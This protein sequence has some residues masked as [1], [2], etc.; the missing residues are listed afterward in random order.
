MVVILVLIVIVAFFIN[1][2]HPCTAAVLV[3]T[4]VKSDLRGFCVSGE[5]GKG[6]SFEG[7][8]KVERGKVGK[9]P[10]ER[11]KGRGRE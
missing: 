3:E 10:G 8:R 6:N 11:S 5:G 2:P 7:G 9:R 4:Q 1:S